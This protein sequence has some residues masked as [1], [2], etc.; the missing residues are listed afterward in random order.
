[1]EE[2][3]VATDETIFVRGM[4]CASCV[5]NVER[6]VMKLDGVAVAE[7]NLA[8]EQLHLRYDST[9]VRQADIVRA[10]EKRGFNAEI[11][12]VG[13]E[14]NL[15]I[16]GMTCASCVN[17]VEK[18][19][20]RLEGVSRAS[21]NLT[22]EKARIEY[23][24]NTVTLSRIKEVIVK[25]G[26]TAKVEESN[27]PLEATLDHREN[28]STVLRR[29]L[30]FSATFAI[31][32]LIVAMGEMLG[33]PLPDWISMELFP[34]RFALTQLFLVIP[35]AIAGYQ[36]YLKGFPALFR[37]APNMDSLIAIG[38]SAALIYSGINTFQTAAGEVHLVHNLYFETAGVIITLILFGKYL[39][40]RSKGRTS[41]AIKKLL[42]LRPK[43]A[44]LI[45]ENKE[46]SVPID[47]VK[48]GDMIEVR[49][50][51]KFPV[52]GEVIEG[53]STVDESMLTGE[54]IPVEKKAGDTVTGASFNQHGV[55]R[56]RAAR[57]G[58]DT[59][60][61]Q[62]IRLVENAQAGKAPIARLADIISGYFVPTVMLIAVVSGIAW[63]IGGHP[64]TFAL[65]IFIAVLVIACPCALGLATP[66]AIMVGTGK[67][68]EFGILIKGGGPLETAHKLDYIVLDKTGTITEG[69]PYVT[70]ILTTDTLPEK[71]LL[72][73][74]A[75][76]EK[77]SE[78]S[79]GA[80]ILFEA[81]RQDVSLV[82][83]NHFLA[84]P[85]QGIKGK[86]EEKHLL[87][88]N[89]RLMQENHILTAPMSEAERL[90]D[91]GKTPMYVAVDNNVI[92]LIAVADVVKRDS[93]K[94]IAQLHSLGL[95]T[96]MLTGDSERTATGIARQ[97]GIDRIIAEVMPGD[98]A[99]IIKK[100]QEE[101]W[102]VGMVGDGIND[103]PALAQADVGIA[104]GSGTDVAIESADIVLMR[105]S[106][107]GVATAIELSKHT[108]RN[109][110]QNLF[111]AFA[112]NIAGIPVA[113]GVLYLLGGPVLNP[114]IAAGAMA[115]SSVSVV[116]NALRLKN[117]KPT[118]L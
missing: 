111:W 51:E 95:K 8:T 2:T 96:V 55:I 47:E 99:Q 68:A 45:R 37:G 58:T 38:T 115:M 22:T 72:R 117:F 30:L 73:L 118:I 112:Y 4:S 83:A 57:V 50:G 77:G 40:S 19:L 71:E 17:R 39:E 9:K 24:P 62:I 85:G 54:S 66:T 97:V 107:T 46:I 98:K 59:T 75:S 26:Y 91:E 7:V 43:T 110:K 88:G 27:S 6:S 32:L 84:V 116:T 69:K 21:V 63:Y 35:V 109:I 94:A 105:H 42:E 114:M 34:L 104:I 74:A 108:I 90:A 10:I 36:F 48:V 31:P 67:G 79:L 92:G 1:M 15:Q 81:Q 80:A 23:D 41:Q 3:N 76:A 49:P 13:K 12:Q 78:H 65:A 102:K 87:L 106:L 29:K 5:R 82:K 16:E 89:Y 103:A 25:A 113:A 33:L 18:T 14:L 52:D 11:P 28:E 100:L 70:D 93:A 86:I 101:G 56:F 20:N 61:S 53:Q 64:L 60:L 44:R